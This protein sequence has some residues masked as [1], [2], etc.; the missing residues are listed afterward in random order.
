V[1]NTVL[2]AGLILVIC[3]L[4]RRLEGSWTAPAVFFAAMWAGLVGAYGLIFPDLDDFAAGAGWILLACS[5]TSAGAL[6]AHGRHPDRPH[7][8]MP[9]E[10][11]RRRLPMLFGITLVAN[12][13]GVIEITYLFA[14]RGASPFSSLDILAL[15]AANRAGNYGWAE[16]TFQAGEWPAVLLLYT[17]ALF[18]GALFRLSRRRR[19]TFSAV[20]SVLLVSLVFAFYGSR[21]GALY[22]GS[23][24]L[25]AY[26]ATRNLTNES[27]GD[28]GRL[29]LRVGLGAGLLL[30][31]GSVGT[32]VLRY[33]TQLG[34]VGWR[35]IFADGFSF[36]GAFS[37]W[38]RDHGWVWSDLAWGARTFNKIVAPF[39]VHEAPFG[40]I[41]VGFTSSNIYTV[42]RDVL[43]DFGVAGSLVFFALLG[44][45]GRLADVGVRAGHVALVGVSVV[46]YTF[47]LTS[48]ATSVYFYTAPTVALFLFVIYTLMAG[49]T[50]SWTQAVPAP[51]APIT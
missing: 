2:L 29:L 19:E 46:V 45:V 7:L 9:M 28:S 23:F 27:G 37:I 6:A 35:S 25:A 49:R 34:E 36:V 47:M 31:G 48:F 26:L 4:T 13:S 5:A 15:V 50:D 43:E 17:G 42:F 39:G 22:G 18:G 14:R 40:I 41:D 20:L 10:E 1:T 21:F 12:I 51:G 33:W 3:V 8:P 30:A 44:Y 24:W 16:Q 38:F 32:Q 11:A